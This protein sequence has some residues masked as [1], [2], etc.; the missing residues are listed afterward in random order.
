MDILYPAESDPVALVA[1]LRAL[2]DDIERLAMFRP[3][4]VL[5]DAPVLDDW[6]VTTRQV[7]AL[8]GIVTSHPILGLRRAIITSEVYAF[9]PRAK[10]ARTYSRYY[11]LGK[12]AT[13]PETQR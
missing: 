2:A 7:T 8:S 10:W 6:R 13:V 1:K 4:E 5:D 12:R 11:R 9:N 3:R